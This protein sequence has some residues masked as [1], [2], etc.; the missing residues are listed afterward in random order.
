MAIW[1]EEADKVVWHR[2]IGHLIDGYL[3]AACGW[4]MAVHQGRICPEKRHETGLPEAQRCHNCVS[5]S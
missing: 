3:P 2:V 5:T 4:R 1:V